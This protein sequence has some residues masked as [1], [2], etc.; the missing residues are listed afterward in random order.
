MLVDEE[1]D[2][3]VLVNTIGILQGAGLFVIM[4]R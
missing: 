3:S 2:L 1:K 4:G